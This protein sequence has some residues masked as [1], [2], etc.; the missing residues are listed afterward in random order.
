MVKG[1]AF[2]TGF[3]DG[4]TKAIPKLFLWLS[5][6]VG[7]FVLILI[8]PI[9]V[10]DESFHLFRSF[11]VS[12]GGWLAVRQ[13]NMLGG[14]IPRGLREVS[15]RWHFVARN[16]RTGRFDLN[17]HWRLRTI[18]L[19][20]TVKE[21]V[22]FPSPALYSPIFYLPQAA[23]ISLARVFLPPWY[24]LYFGRVSNLLICVLIGFITLRILPH[25]QWLFFLLMMTPTAIFQRSSL[26]CDALV[27]GLGH[28]AIAFAFCLALRSGSRIRKWEVVLSCVLCFFMAQAK[29]TYV[30]VPF[31]F[32]MVGSNALGSG[33]RYF[34]F[35]FLVTFSTLIGFL[36]WARVVALIHIPLSPTSNAFSQI[37]FCIAEP[38]VVLKVIANELFKGWR[39]Y[40]RDLI[41]EHLGWRDVVLPRSFITWYVNAM[42]VISLFAPVSRHYSMLKRGVVLSIGVLSYFLIGT[43]IYI[44]NM[45]VGALYLEGL[46]GRYL[47]PLSPLFFMPFSGVG[48]QRR[49]TKE[50]ISKRKGPS[51]DALGSGL[52]P[53]G[54]ASEAPPVDSKPDF[55]GTF[56]MHL[57]SRV[58]VPII[59]LGFTGFGI[60]LM[61]KTLA[62]HHYG[63]W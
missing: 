28:L 49:L 9:Q 4:A 47:T 15:D 24:F 27:N 37:S 6:T 8:P 51:A 52:P 44:I 14:L 53:H 62:F 41:G 46:Q 59:T 34:C 10:A 31:I 7:L 57:I 54:F 23:G 19:Q 25:L 32:F 42:I 26:S 36:S 29:S 48:M 63:V 21:F 18:P 33:K 3:G 1:W 17:E 5:L 45:R 43:V 60:Y 13:N 12:E 16:P 38:F 30:L 50:F 55:R 39:G 2:V 22:N 56:I 35:L 20:E 61:C 40:L 58:L 11:Q